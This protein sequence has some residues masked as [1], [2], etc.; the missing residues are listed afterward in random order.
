MLNEVHNQFIVS[1]I[2]DEAI[3]LLN[4]EIGV[5]INGDEF[6]KDLFY[7]DSLGKKVIKVF[8]NCIG[9]KVIDSYPIYNAILKTKTPVDTYNVGMCASAGNN[10]FQAGRKRYVNDYALTMVHPV[11]GGSDAE[12]TNLFNDSI[13]TM[14]MRRTNKTEAEIRAMVANTTWMNA[15]DCV[16]NGFADEICYS[17]SSNKP[18]L[19]SKAEDIENNLSQIKFYLNSITNNSHKMKS[20]TNKLNLNEGANE[21]LIV[22]SIEAIENK[23][24]T[25]NAELEAAKNAANEAMEKYNQ[26]KAKCDAME[27]ENIAKAATELENKV[28]AEVEAIK[29]ANKVS[30]KPEAIEALTNALTAN[31]ES[32]KLLY[33]SM[34]VNKTG[35]NIQTVAATVSNSNVTTGAKMMHDLR[36]KL[37]I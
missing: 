21:A 29:K 18:R 15:D 30:D 35:V 26:M 14:M 7:A 8:I 3:L 31:F 34:P 4:G 2:N 1:T 25:A 36:N 24:S 33:D 27:A 22:S 23:L 6:A 19:T 5:D 28:K 16:K 10:I 37:G 20:V 13:V 11:S 32:T 12:M 9:G 17:S